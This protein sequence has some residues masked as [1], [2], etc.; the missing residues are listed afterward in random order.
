MKKILLAAVLLLSTFNLVS[1][2]SEEVKTEETSLLASKVIVVDGKEEKYDY[3]YDDNN[4]LITVNLNGQLFE[5]RTYDDNKNVIKAEREDTVY[6][7]EYNQDN[8]LIKTTTKYA[9]G[10]EDVM[11]YT[12]NDNQ[13]IVKTYLTQK[14]AYSSCEYEYQEG[15]KVISCDLS[16]ESMKKEYY[17]YDDNN[18]VIKEEAFIDGTLIYTKT[19]TI[20]NNL[21]TSNLVTFPDSDDKVVERN[22]YDENGNLLRTFVKD[23][24]EEEVLLVENT[25]QENTK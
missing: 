14:D 15:Q 8:L 17:Y 6:T 4:L 19:N 20:E 10:S 21:I 25:Y 5:K 18:N 9:D 7:N 1:C 24:D 23:N 2:N 3:V 12:Y 11:E 16:G 13:E 22:E